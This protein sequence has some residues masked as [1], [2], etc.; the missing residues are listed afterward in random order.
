MQKRPSG[1]ESD[2]ATERERERER[3]GAREMKGELTMREKEGKESKVHDTASE[4]IIET[5]FCH[6]IDMAFVVYVIVKITRN[7]TFFMRNS[8][9]FTG[10]CVPMWWW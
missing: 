10:N 3:D 9:L 4:C 8:Y 1:K 7:G 6:S 2:G 5:C